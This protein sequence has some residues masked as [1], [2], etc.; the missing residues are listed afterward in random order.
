MF[1]CFIQRWTAETADKKSGNYIILWRTALQNM[2]FQLYKIIQF[3]TM[4]KSLI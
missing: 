1:F 2:N 4:Q 3:K